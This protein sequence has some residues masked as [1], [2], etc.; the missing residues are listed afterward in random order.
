MSFKSYFKDFHI[1]FLISLI[2][3]LAVCDALYGGPHILHLGVEFVGGTE[4][5]VELEHPVNPSTM[6]TLLSTLQER[7]TTFGLKQVTVEGIGSSEVYVII[8]SV[9]KSEIESTMSLIESQGVFQGIVDGK[10]AINGTS[11]IPDS[12]G[13]L[14]PEEV[15]GTVM[16]QVSFYITQQ[17]A[18]KFAKV[19]FGQ[20]NKPLYMF[21]DRPTSAILL[22]NN[23]IVSSEEAKGI[24][25]TDFMQAIY[26]ATSF[27]NQSIPVEF[28]GSGNLTRLVTLLS[29]DRSRYSKLIMASNAPKQI[30]ETANSLNYTISYVSPKN[31][32]PVISVAV[33][34]SGKVTSIV[35]S[36]PAI[37]LLSAPILSPS[38]TNGSISQSYEISGYAPAGLSLAAKMAYAENQSTLIVSILKGGALPV[39]VIA[40]TY[41]IIPPTLGK[42]FEIVSGVALLVAVIAVSLFISIRYRKRFLIFPIIFTTLSE[43]F[44]IMSIIGLL[45]TIDL[46]AV[47]GMIAVIGTGVDA[48]IIITDE[49][50]GRHGNYTEKARLHNAF[51]IIWADAA[52]LV[53]AMLPLFFS[54]SL[55]QIVGFAEST[56]LGVLFGALITRPAYGAMISKH[57]SQLENETSK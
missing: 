29:S 48:Q 39:P 10:E 13:A 2:L 45:G 15:N 16:W 28:Y 51:F 33:G 54:T 21:L 20:G 32:T 47:A 22:L 49:F 24:N 14:P 55:V 35:N 5:P 44:I 23:S 8:P 52:L 17:A 41:T 57:F 42:H 46:A 9:S 4:I 25:Y 26:S 34:P 3:L 37:G 18:M 56:M 53:I 43:L 7:L 12:I 31:I 27:G 38:I 11:L 50:I 40:N 1:D 6:S 30:I 19:V 36:W